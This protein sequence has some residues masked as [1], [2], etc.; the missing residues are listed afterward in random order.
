MISVMTQYF[1]QDIFG[2]SPIKNI[3]KVYYFNMN[4]DLALGYDL[5][6]QNNKVIINDNWFLN[7]FGAKTY[8]YYE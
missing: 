1:D 2:A 7:F 3:L 4:Y 8:S 6:I 5:S